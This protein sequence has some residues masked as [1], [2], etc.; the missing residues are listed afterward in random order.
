M[1][2]GGRKHCRIF[3]GEDGE[4]LEVPAYL[5]QRATTPLLRLGHEAAGVGLRAAGAGV[6]L[7]HLVLLRRFRRLLSLGDRC[8]TLGERARR[9]ERGRLGHHGRGARGA[10]TAERGQVAGGAGRAAVLVVVAAD[11]LLNKGTI[12]LFSRKHCWMYALE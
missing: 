7:N 2:P 9:D 3:Q 11:G 10:G 4:L 5:R 8:R 6:A 12:K 1:P